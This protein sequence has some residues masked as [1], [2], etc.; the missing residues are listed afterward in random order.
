[1]IGNVNKGEIFTMLSLFVMDKLSHIKI[2]LLVPVP[3]LQHIQS[4]ADL[5]MYNILNSVCTYVHT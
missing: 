1:M 5:Y 4:V 2:L 3:P